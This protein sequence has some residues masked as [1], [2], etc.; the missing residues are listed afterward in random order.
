MAVA[1][2]V[3]FPP[4]AVYFH[5]NN[6]GEEELR[7]ALAWN[8]GKIVVD[9]F[10]ELELLERLDREA[11]LVQ[12]ILIRVSPG[13]TPTPIPTPRRASWTASLAS[14]SRRARPRRRYAWL[15]GRLP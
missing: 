6:K 7:D 9:S 2:A 12:E 14:P 5:G 13:S 1:K 10:Y 11:K 4:E 8:M 3:D 15:S